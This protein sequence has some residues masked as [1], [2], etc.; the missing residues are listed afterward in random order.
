MKF[1]NNEWK[2]DH[3]LARNKKFFLY[4]HQNNNEIN[5]IISRSIERG[6]I[7][8]VLGFIKCSLNTKLSDVATVIWKVSKTAKSPFLGVEL[9]RFL[10]NLPQVRTIFSVGINKKTV[11]IYTYLGM[12]TGTLDHFVLLNANCKNFRVAKVL[13]PHFPVRID[14]IPIKEGYSVTSIDTFAKIKHYGFDKFENVIPYKDS[15]YYQR[16]YF[17]H[18]IYKYQ[19]FGLKF[20]EVLISIVFTRI[21]ES[22]KGNVLRIVDFV[23]PESTFRYY[24]QFFN[25]FM[26]ENN[27]EYTD[28][29]CYGID[30][31]SVLEA[32]FIDLKLKESE[33]LIIPNYFSPFVQKNVD[34]LFF[35]DSQKSSNIKLFKADG[36]Q[37]RPS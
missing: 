37:D 5:F 24:S 4:E 19:V 9:L 1:I 35:V 32:G 13:L 7:I 36:D 17:A 23:G 3:I 30:K 11:G 31:E 21:Q 34:I 12:Q 20:N 15:Y 33:E 27:L 8:G 18:P 29:Y 2:L 25:S 6:S 28:I 16:R 10:Q 26:Q 14:T 22:E